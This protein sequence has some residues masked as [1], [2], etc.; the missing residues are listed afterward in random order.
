MILPILLW[1]CIVVIVALLTDI[2]CSAADGPVL[3]GDTSNCWSPR[4]PE[5]APSS[6]NCSRS[7]VPS[8]SK[9]HTTLVTTRNAHNSRLVTL[10]VEKKFRLIQPPFH[11]SRVPYAADNDRQMAESVHT[12][13]NIYW[14]LFPVHAITLRR[15]IIGKLIEPSRF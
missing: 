13:V 1:C 2:Y 4:E 9:H 10:L 6:T 11:H 5:V 3:S 15:R 7:P 8:N 12:A 14:H